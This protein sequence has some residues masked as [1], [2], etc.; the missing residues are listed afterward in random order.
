[1]KSV[2]GNIV[3]VFTSKIF[4]GEVI[5]EE[6]RIRSI[7]K[8]GPFV[9]RELYVL[10]GLVDA[11]VHIESSMLVPVNFA[12]VAVKHGTVA[13][14]SDPH[15]IGNVL[16]VEGMK[17]M[18]QNGNQSFLKFF[19]GVPSCVPATSFESSGAVID[20]LSVE[21]LLQ[22]YNF[23]SLSEVMNFP[24]V[25]NREREMMC[26]IETA[27]KYNKRI[28]GH[29]PGLSGIDLEKYATAG[30]STDHECSSIEE[31]EEK[32]GFGIKIQI[33]EG[34]SAKNF[35]ALYPLIDKYPDMVMLCCDDIHPE[36]LIQ[37]HI[38]RLLA[39]GISKGVDIF[40]LL[41]AATVNPVNHYGLNV[42]LLR[43]GDSADFIL[44]KDLKSFKIFQTWI[45]GKCVYS[46]SQ[47][48][49]AGYT[50]EFINRF[51]TY[52]IYTND[53]KIINTFRNY[54]VIEVLDGELITKSLIVKN[55]SSEPYL[56]SDIVNDCLKIVVVNRYKKEK[57]AIGFVKNFGLK[58]GAISSSV[59][60]DSHNIIAIGVDDN[61]IMNAI[62]SIMD[63]KGG[64]SV[65]DDDQF[66]TLP[67]PVAGLMSMESAE[68][69]ADTYLRL[70][71]KVKDLGSTLSSPFMTMSFLA[72]LV[73]PELKISDKGL[74]DVTKFQL[75]D[76]FV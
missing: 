18:I 68:I 4:F 58:R 44:V 9:D 14:V 31:A 67:L 34:S 64:I 76:L 33:R 72:L 38:N 24:G 26:K 39:L 37:G 13:V 28:D 1:M 29:A 51:I 75:M 17:F 16:G 41:R 27:L 7:E 56:E 36:D 8:I 59:A 48:L 74:F 22:A 62:T 52:T 12:T 3:D 2:R 20:S 46:E 71:K 23:V 69:V 35:D 25:V 32:I 43:V 66:L 42:G 11:H 54:R 19:W 73:I 10:P 49:E 63:L 53:L 47:N 50:T 45:D 21:S 70:N 60:H 40:K 57:P 65:V 30:I 15:E 5:I 6:G 61:D 55:M